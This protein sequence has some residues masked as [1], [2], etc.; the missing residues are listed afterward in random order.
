MHILNIYDVMMYDVMIY[1][2]MIYDVMMYDVMMYDVWYIITSWY[3]WK[4]IAIVIELLKATNMYNDLHG[5]CPAQGFLTLHQPKTRI[6]MGTLVY[7][8]IFFFFFL[9][10]N[11][12]LIQ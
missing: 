7:I 3:N 6:I 10:S 9:D 1:D 12:S 8:Y 5:T 4:Y 11:L 2:V